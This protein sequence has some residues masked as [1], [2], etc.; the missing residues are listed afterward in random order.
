MVVHAF[1]ELKFNRATDKVLREGGHMPSKAS[2]GWFL[3]LL[4]TTSFDFS[5]PSL[6]IQKGFGER[7]ELPLCQDKCCLN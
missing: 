2:I 6:V 3:S 7:T 1:T 4:F 5:R